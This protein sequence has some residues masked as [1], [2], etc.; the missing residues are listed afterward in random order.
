MKIIEI[1]LTNHVVIP[2][3]FHVYLK[4][5]SDIICIDGFNGAGKSFLINNIH[6]LSSNK[7]FASKYAIITGRSGLKRIVYQL[8]INREFEIIHEYIPSGKTHSCKSYC[9]LIEGGI[10]TELNPT[11]HTRRFEEIIKEY[12]FF[13]L[14]TFICSF[15]STKGDSIVNA[16]PTNRRKIMETTMKTSKL[17]STYQTNNKDTLT[18]INAGIKNY[19]IQIQDL[20]NKLPYKSVVEFDNTIVDSKIELKNLEI[21]K[22]KLEENLSKQN[23]RLGRLNST[24]DTSGKLLSMHKILNMLEKYSEYGI[25][26]SEIFGN[27]DIINSTLLLND[28]KLSENNKRISVLKS[29]IEDMSLLD[30]TI[31]Q[32]DTLKRERSEL[33]SQVNNT[34]KDLSPL[35]FTETKMHITNIYKSLVALYQLNTDHIQ[36]INSFEY[37]DKIIRNDENKVLEI[38]NFINDYAE[39]SVS[40]YHNTR[41]LNDFNID[42]FSDNSK[43]SNCELYKQIVLVSKYLEE[44]KTKADKYKLELDELETRLSQLNELR[45]HRDIINEVKDSLNKILYDSFLNTLELNNI[46]TLIKNAISKNMAEVLSSRFNIFEVSYRRLQNLEKSIGD[47]ELQLA[48]TS[49]VDSSAILFEINSLEK[50]SETLRT[51]F[52]QYIGF[53]EYMDNLN[54]PRELLF[55][56]TLEEVNIRYDD[57]RNISNTISELK[58]EITIETSTL[59]TVDNRIRDLVSRITNLENDKLKLIETSRHLLAYQDKLTRHTILKDILEKKIPLKLLSENASFIEC[60]VNSILEENEIALSLEFIIDKDDIRIPIFTRNQEVDDIVLASS[61]EMCLLS[62]V[63]NAVIL[64]IIGY[65]VISFDEMTANLDIVY[66][67]KFYNLLNTIMEKLDI[68]QIFCVSHEVSHDMRVSHIVLGNYDRSLLLGDFI[69][70]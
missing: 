66:R 34:V 54:A 27:Y 53:K 17:L 42:E 9:N 29:K 49:S 32:L 60:M 25:T 14:N 58:N 7:R 26:S 1:E 6:P 4:D 52:N 5:A 46:D 64:H 31:K 45:K 24:E 44:N 16:T 56:N 23:I 15:L 36:D 38:R 68:H 12:L 13:D 20:Y 57:L 22:S 19:K 62:V 21:K 70:Y 3:N 47:I 41:G 67:D 8:D 18:N 59:K 35:N 11:G 65:S 10:K 50:E 63:L 61:G 39:K 40:A 2:A 69:E 43:C 33:N 51:Y 30:S 37:V 55:N 48:K 28:Y